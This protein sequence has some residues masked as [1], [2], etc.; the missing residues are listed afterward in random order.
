M[1]QDLSIGQ[2]PEHPDFVEV[3]SKEK[4]PSGKWKYK[5][6]RNFRDYET[7]T[8]CFADHTKILLL[9]RYA[10]AFEQKDVFAF[11]ARIE[12][13]GYATGG[14]YAKT[15]GQIIRQYNLTQYDT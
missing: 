11:A 1:I 8:Q 2:H 12:A 9:P 13:G 5:L 4:Q 7:P 3:I 10:S 14:N 15:I 6:T